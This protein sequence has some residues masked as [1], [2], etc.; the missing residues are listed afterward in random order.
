MER[1]VALPF[2]KSVEIAYKSIRVRFFRSLITTLSLVLAVA[3]LCYVLAGNR[4]AEGILQSGDASAV[5]ALVRAG[6]DVQPG[7]ETIAGSAKQLWLIVLS[8]LVCVVGIVNAQLM[9][10]TERFREIGTM[11]CLGALDRFIL[12]LFLLEAFMQGLAGASSGALIGMIFALISAVLIF[13]N[14]ALINLPLAQLMLTILFS[15]AVGCFLSLAGVIYPAGK[16][17]RMQPVE[18]MRIEE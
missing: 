9:A 3:F 7:D 13:G 15:T 8:L 10:V 4:I 5:E 14:L 17:A 6:Y 11:K 18:A 1:L 2:G 16:A 12:R